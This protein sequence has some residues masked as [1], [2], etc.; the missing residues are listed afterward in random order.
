M[1]NGAQ[2]QYFNGSNWTNFLREPSGLVTATSAATYVEG[3]HNG[4]AKE[5][6][7]ILQDNDTDG[8]IMIP[9]LSANDILRP[10]EGLIVY[11]TDR[12]AF[13]FYNGDSWNRVK[14]K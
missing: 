14:D 12:K 9:T 1:A 10:V 2:L 13:L 8:A 6:N 3:V 7:A 11:D 5:D 4:V